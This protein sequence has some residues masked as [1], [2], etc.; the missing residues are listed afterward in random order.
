MYPQFE[1]NNISHEV[2]STVFNKVGTCKFGVNFF[3]PFHDGGTC[4]GL[5]GMLHFELEV[6]D[7]DFSLFNSFDNALDLSE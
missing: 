6:L 1:W 4:S 7:F 2:H 5:E 3:L